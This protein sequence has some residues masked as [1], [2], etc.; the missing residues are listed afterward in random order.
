M[1]NRGEGSMET[2]EL[3]RLIP[4]EKL[5]Y[6][7]QH[8]DAGADLDCSFLGF[9]DIY[10]DVLRAVPKDKVIIDLGCAYATQSWF[11][12][13]HVKYIGVDFCMNE[14]SV[15][16]TENSAFYFTSIQQFISEM[17]PALKLDLNDVFAVCSYVP[18][19]EARDLVLGTFPYCYVYY[20]E[21]VSVFRTDRG[22]HLRSPL[23]ER[24]QEANQRASSRTS[25]QNS[26]EPVSR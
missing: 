5:Q 10:L 13:E 12:R 25:C 21:T 15:I 3:F 11:F 17:L 9:E 14:D 6:L 7:F 8:S 19:E 26:F 1:Q 24:I 4:K 18:D 20:P 2:C 23:V 22:E 16:H